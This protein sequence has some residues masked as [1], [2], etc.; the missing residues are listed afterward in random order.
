MQ[1]FPMNMN[2]NAAPQQSTISN[3]TVGTS[4]PTSAPKTLTNEAINR[5]LAASVKVG[6]TTYW[7]VAK[8]TRTLKLTGSV[9]YVNKNHSTRQMGDHFVYWEPFRVA[10]TVSDIVGTFRA[11]G[12][13]TVNVGQGNQPL[14]EQLVAQTAIDPLNPEH[15]AAIDQMQ[16]QGT[17]A[18]VGAKKTTTLHTLEQYV[19]IGNALKSAGKNST[20]SSTGTK[21]S[22]AATGKGGN[23]PQA[24]QQRLVQS[25]N[26]AMTTALSLPSGVN[27]EKVFEVTQFDPTKFSKAPLKAPPKSNKAT[28]IQPVVNVQGRQIMVPIIAQQ[29]GVN[30][31][32]AFVNSVVGVSQYANFAQV[33]QQSFDQEV[34]R[35]STAV[36]VQGQGFLA[37][38]QGNVMSMMQQPAFTSL[39]QVGF[40]PAGVLLPPMNMMNQIGEVRQ[41]GSPT[42]SYG[43]TSP[44][45]I[46]LGSGSPRGGG[47][48]LPRINM[49]QLPSVSGLPNAFGALPSVAGGGSVFPSI[50]LPT[51]G[52]SPMGL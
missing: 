26:Q 6:P 52:T 49:G 32:R 1:Q 50:Q 28:A 20:T 33:I 2:M 30:N 18:G 48:A 35:R 37:P 38:Q 23:T 44:A 45:P 22:G 15:R 14:T 29:T 40:Q 31:F 3:I 36:G 27:S 17:G 11:A 47:V 34:Q 8:P 21:S 25:F 10:G 16:K 19:I 24:K 7:Q 13:S 46:S 9:A 41:A 42:S 4:V 5:H 39:P 12:I 51:Q 43:L